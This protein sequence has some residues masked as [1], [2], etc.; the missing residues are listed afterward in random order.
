MISYWASADAGSLDCARSSA[1]G[2]FFFARDD[3]VLVRSTMECVSRGV[4]RSH[5]SQRTRKMGHPSF[6]VLQSAGDPSLGVLWLCLGLRCL[7]M[8]ACYENG[9]W[10]TRLLSDVMRRVSLP[11]HHS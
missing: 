10:A 9:G 6:L 1:G 7:G 11:I 8:T 5:L 3:R 4:R 2:R